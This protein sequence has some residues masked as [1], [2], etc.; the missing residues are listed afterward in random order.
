MD[1]RQEKP[2]QVGFVRTGIITLLVFC[3]TA[4]GCSPNANTGPGETGTPTL[5]QMLADLESEIP[6][7][8]WVA[9]KGLGE[10][11][12]ARAVDPLIAALNDEDPDI[13]ME[14]ANALGE[15]LDARAIEPLL[16]A[17]QEENLEIIAGAYRFF[18]GRGQAGTEEILIWALNEFG[19][20]DMA[21]DFLNCGNS[22]LEEAGTQWAH[23]HG[24]TISSMPFGSGGE[25]PVWGS[26]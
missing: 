22:L 21:E 18:I 20:S 10:L 24:Y 6:I 23:T 12:D 15:I 13:R 11:K 14:A 8:R 25:D 7:I 4:I 26:G 1:N 16:T 9:I 5:E 17:L 2:G 19:T 3:L